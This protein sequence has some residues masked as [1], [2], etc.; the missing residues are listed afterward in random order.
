MRSSRSWVGLIVLAVVSIA[1]DRLCRSMVSGGNQEQM[2]TVAGEAV[3]KLPESIGAWRAVESPDLPE[4]A[5]AMLQCRAHK[6]RVY[7]NDETGER[8]SMIL[9]VGVPGPLVAHTPE[10][11]YGSSAFE[12]IGGTEPEVVRGTGDQADTLNRVRFQS[13][14]LGGE[15]QQVYYGWRPPAGR[16]KAPKNPRLDLT[17]WPL[18]YKIQL[19]TVDGASSE[20][21]ADRAEPKE[22]VNRRFLEVLLPVLDSLLQNR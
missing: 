6:S 1:G 9:L 18:L 5:L 8:V 15:N 19:A 22:S 21:R 2:L 10:I 12:I 11:C 4:S 7:V 14:T 13:K 20:N 16:W 17:G 3:D